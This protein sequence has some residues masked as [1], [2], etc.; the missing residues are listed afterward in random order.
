MVKALVYEA[1]GGVD[2]FPAIELY[3][4]WNANPG[5]EFEV[6]LIQFFCVL[7]WTT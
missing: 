1:Q 6:S 5:G 4:N 7:S 2:R 3:V